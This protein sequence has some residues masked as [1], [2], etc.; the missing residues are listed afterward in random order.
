MIKIKTI[1]KSSATHLAFS[2]DRKF[3]SL[4]P[5]KYSISSLFLMGSYAY[6]KQTNLSDIDLLIVIDDC[7]LFLKHYISDLIASDLNIPRSWLTILTKDHFSR[8]YHI[9][10]ILLSYLQNKCHVIFSKD[11]SEKQLVED[12]IPPY[13]L[14]NVLE[15][16]KY[17]F[18]ENFK[19]YIKG[20]ALPS[21]LIG[22]IASNL[23]SIFSLYY[24]DFSFNKRSNL[25][26][27]LNSSD[28]VVPF[29]AEEYDYIYYIK[30]FADFYPSPPLIPFRKSFVLTW[31]NRYVRL[32]EKMLEF[33]N[34]SFDSN[35]Y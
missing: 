10:S 30:Q 19:S 18:D 22:D 35:M 9:G 26:K 31:C 27:A 13:S 23:R 29:T 15:E 21:T 1:Y 11:D 12:P 7:S 16:D 2:V 3:F 14:F 25:I 28:F 33:K 24:K 32:Y 8:L 6:G 20:D 34:N 17:L 4:N 5:E